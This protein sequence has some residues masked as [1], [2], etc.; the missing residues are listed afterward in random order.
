M[1]FI[2]EEAKTY[3]Q[4]ARSARL[5]EQIKEID[6]LD[7]E[8]RSDLKILYDEVNYLVD[9]YMDD[10][11]VPREEYLDAK[12]IM[13]ETENGKCMPFNPITFKA[14]YSSRQVSDAKALV[15]EVRR[16]KRLSDTLCAKIYCKDD[17]DEDKRKI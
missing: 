3:L 15:N 9:L 11:T 10:D 4:K 12:K 13:R 2:D 6:E 17:D 1:K 7:R 14:R 8:G 16:L 5:D